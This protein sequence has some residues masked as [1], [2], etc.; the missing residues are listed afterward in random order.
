MITLKGEQD[1]I[2]DG[3]EAWVVAAIG[4][5]KRTGGIGDVLAG[6]MATTLHKAKA[7]NTP[8]LHAAVASCLITKAAARAACAEHGL[9][10]TAPDVISKLGH[11]LPTFLSS[12]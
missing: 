1:I 6:T 9:S 7:T 10:M 8:L 3:K 5:R 2:T 12:L 11:V 4:S